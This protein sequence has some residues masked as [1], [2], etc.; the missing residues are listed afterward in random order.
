MVKA[1]S[2]KIFD[3]VA[4]EDVVFGETLGEGK[5][6]TKFKQPKFIYIFRA[7]L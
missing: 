5:Q 2:A 3:G 1:S 4:P 7:C 6:L